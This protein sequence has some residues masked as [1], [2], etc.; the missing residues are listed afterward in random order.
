MSTPLDSVFINSLKHRKSLLSPAL[1][2]GEWVARHFQDVFEFKILV[3]NIFTFFFFFSPLLCIYSNLSAAV[4]W[5]IREWI[6]ASV[7][8]PGCRNIDYGVFGVSDFDTAILTVRKSWNQAVPLYILT[9]QWWFRSVSAHFLFCFI[10][11]SSFL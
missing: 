7:L 4:T 5:I 1:S 11:T 3:R 9:T 2:F 8:L 6:Q 10:N